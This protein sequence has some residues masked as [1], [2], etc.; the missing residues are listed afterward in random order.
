[1]ADQ[2]S[3]ALKDLPEPV[4]EGAG[5][6]TVAP[7]ATPQPPPPGTT[8]TPTN[9]KPVSDNKWTNEL[10]A[11][12]ANELMQ[13]NPGVQGALADFFKFAG[14]GT[15]RGLAEAAGM[16][17]DAANTMGAFVRSQGAAAPEGGE[18]PLAPPSLRMLGG[19]PLLAAPALAAGYIKEALYPG[20]DIQTGSGAY[21]RQ[22]AESVGLPTSTPKEEGVTSSGAF[23]GDIMGEFGG[24]NLPFLAAMPAKI[25]TQAGVKTVTNLEAMLRSANPVRTIAKE[26]VLGG[27]APGL[28]AGVGAHAVG[29]EHEDLGKAAG[30]I[31]G[32]LRT[33]LI[34]SGFGAAKGASA[35]M[36]EFL[37]FGTGA[38]RV[39]GKALAGTAQDLPG[40]L[41]ALK[42]DVPISPGAVIPVDIK[43]G[44]EGLIALRRTVAARDAELAGDYRRMQQATEE[45]LKTDAQLARG[46]FATTEEWLAARQ[47]RLEELSNQRLLQAV[48]QAERDTS[49]AFHG[50]EPLREDANMAKNRYATNLRREL[51]NAEDDLNAVV[52]SKWDKVDQN[53]PVQ[54]EPVY[55]RVRTMQAEHAARPGEG[56]DRFPSKVMGRFFDEA[57]DP[58]FGVN[59]RL[60]DVIDL[61]SEIQQAIRAQTALDAPDRVYVSY[62]KRVS[63]AL[64]EAK[65]GVPAADKAALQDAIGAT[66]N[67]H[68]TFHRGPVGQTLG[69]DAAGGMDTLPG[70]TIK[71]FLGQGPGGIDSFNAL[72]KAVSARTGQVAPVHPSVEMPQL[73]QKYIRQDFYDTV[74]PNGQFNT[75]AAQKWV[76]NNAGPL[77]TFPELKKEFQNAIMSEGR[78]AQ[79]GQHVKVE[80][81]TI[82]HNQAAL[83]LDGQPGQLFN[84]ALKGPDQYRATKNLVA[85]AKEDPTGR[86]TEGLAQMALDRMLADAITPDKTSAAL[87][88]VNGLRVS[89]WVEENKGV[90]RALDEAIPGLKDRFDR[91]AQ[92]GRYLE[93]YQTSP[94]LPKPEESDTGGWIR[95]VMARVMGAN[96]FTKLSSGGGASIQTAAIGS[97]AF[98]KLAAALTPDQA[99][100]LV[101]RALVD[102][103]LFEILT[104][105]MTNA[106]KAEDNFRR[107]SPYLYSIGIPLA[108]PYL[109]QPEMQPR[110]TQAGGMVEPGNIDLANRP[111]V[112]NQDGK[113]A[114][115]RSMSVN[116]DGKEVLI[117]TISDDGRTLSTDEAIAQYRKTG[118]HLGKFDSPQNATAYAKKLHGDQDRQYSPNP[119]S[120]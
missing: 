76:G 31:A 89:N 18:A 73:L 10:L 114:T 78:A 93:R 91:I 94:R 77:N 63:E 74:M 50:T 84:G 19:S 117:P 112:K 103:D 64:N 30:A 107:V 1:M 27:V 35:W 96:V 38:D 2:W 100:A 88:R 59:T 65:Y 66:R 110:Q 41:Q 116:M 119:E 57:G 72:M 70:E 49:Q 111:V 12:D 92:T 86:A 98:K 7:Q 34:E 105:P 6:P 113:I 25:G 87:Q 83:F 40:T 46:N 24:A 28:G 60:K 39:A 62:L 20:K 61:D 29:P 42:T 43:S 4:A 80:L 3:D 106:A 44:D 109:T 22:K 75:K 45:A 118:R 16:P 47:K 108:Q 97:Q 58:R 11:M 95:T 115:V 37:G 52:K 99:T 32:S 79:V 13:Q 101:R 68:D 36:H 15:V 23:W 120:P 56:P 33:K 17:I 54:M 55:D 82:R 53:L 104:K 51:L 69:L 21:M 14:H 102:K 9:R 90:I 48:E 5:P 85:M 67:F 26:A 71:Q 8:R 81:D